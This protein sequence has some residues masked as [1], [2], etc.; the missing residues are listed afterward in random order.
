VTT[1]RRRIDG[2]FA[3]YDDF[4]SYR[5][6]AGWAREVD[7]VIDALAELCDAG[8]ADAVA[9]LAEHA[10]RRADEAVGYVDDPAG[11]LTM[12]SQRLGE[13]HLRACAEGDP[14]AVELAR[15]LVDLELT[16]ELDGFERAAE[17]YAGV[18]GTEGLAEYRRLIEPRWEALRPQTGG[19]STERF[20]LREAMAGVA[21]AVG[22][23][24][25][26]IEVHRDDLKIPDRYLEIARLLEA[27]GRS[28]EAET[29]GREGLER[30]AGR[31][32]QTPPL[33]EFLAD[34]LR[35]R[36]EP[37]AALEL[38]WEAFTR[39]P[40]LSTYRRL[41]DE[42]GEDA[43]AVRARALESLRRRLESTSGGEPNRAGSGLGGVLVEILAIS[44]EPSLVAPVAAEREVAEA[45]RRPALRRLGGV[46]VGVEGEA[47]G[48]GRGAPVR[49]SRSHRRRAAGWRGCAGGREVVPEVRRQVRRPLPRDH[50][51]AR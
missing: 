35:G 32:W 16:S 9:V 8:H 44:R 1:W 6:A 20:T 26:L 23:P 41:L 31:P 49:P 10:H 33:Q 47:R 29:W 50:G 18:L 46:A 5:E 14:D 45:V 40:S 2:A 15:R 36:G 13:L 12:I 27:A 38:Y 24:D 7:E 3:P 25:Q 30:F 48:V 21:V 17:R 22:D 51:S 19:W 43:D 42:A 4:V 28:D 39:A 34:L 11:W 37:S